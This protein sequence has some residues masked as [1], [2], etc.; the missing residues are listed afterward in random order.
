LTTGGQSGLLNSQITTGKPIMPSAESQRIRATFT[1]NP[2]A[3][4][5]PLDVE[6]REWEESA[7]KMPLPPGTVVE[8]LVADGILCE[9]LT[10][11]Q[12]DSTKLLLWLHGGGYN[13]GSPRTH[14]DLG[15][16]L[17]LACGIPVLLVDYRLAPEHPFPAAIKDVIRVYRWLLKNGMNS[18]NIVIGGDSAGGG[19]AASTLLTLR[20]A[21]DPMPAATVLISPML[22]LAFTGESMASR[23]ALDRLTTEADLRKAAAYYLG[24]GD[25]KKPIASPVYADLRGLSPILIHVGDH[26]VLLSD[27]VTFAER[28]VS[29][30]VEVRL[31]I[32][33]EMWHVFHAWAADLPEARDALNQIGQFV[34]EKLA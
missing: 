16:R 6:R 13:A 10:C 22:D 11:G 20:D 34:R 1:R 30:G 2:E 23:A 31:T 4:N 9:R 28:G 7:L 27:S 5:K 19:L 32:W 12:V 14:R 17:S 33:P 25:P 24:D 8:P 26:E 21:D 15:A 3:A 29:A 18:K